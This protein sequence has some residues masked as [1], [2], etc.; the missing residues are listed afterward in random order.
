MLDRPFVF[1]LCQDCDVGITYVEPTVTGPTGRSRAVKTLVSSATY[2]VLPEAVWRELAIE[3]KRD[4]DFVLADGTTL[5][6][7]VGECHFRL[8]EADATSPVVLGEAADVA[9]L[10][11][12]T[13]ETLGL[14]FNP[15]TRTLH[16]MRMLMAGMG[17]LRLPGAQ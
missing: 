6:R 2:S 8:P 17:S 1:D 15:L 10:G 16:P 5:T 7:R 11:V 4:I 12:V 9:I 3:P 13:L 14:V